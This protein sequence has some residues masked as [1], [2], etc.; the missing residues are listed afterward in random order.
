MTPQID[1]GPQILLTD[2]DDTLWSSSIQFENVIAS[3]ESL[4]QPF[5]IEPSLFRHRLDENERRR[6]PKEGYGIAKFI[7]SLVDT[8]QSLVHPRADGILAAR[9]RELATHTLN[10]QPV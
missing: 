10:Q 6:I 9:V 8:F 3:V 7:T 4:L 2:A 5:G 1:E